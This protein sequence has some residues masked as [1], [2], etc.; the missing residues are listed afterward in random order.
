MHPQTHTLRQLHDT[1]GPPSVATTGITI[2]R[3]M[4]LT[5]QY[6]QVAGWVQV[7]HRPV[8]DGLEP[9]VAAKGPATASERGHQT[10]CGKPRRSSLAHKGD[11]TIG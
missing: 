3:A 4:L 2:S 11:P 9:Y 7:L 5:T 10:Q 6:G 8:A 1:I